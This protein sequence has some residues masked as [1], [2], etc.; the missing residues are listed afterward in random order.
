VAEA[1]RPGSFPMLGSLRFENFIFFISARPFFLMDAPECAIYYCIVATEIAVFG[2]SD[3]LGKLLQRTA[4]VG[5]G[6][7]RNIFVRV[8]N[9]FFVF[10]KE[11]T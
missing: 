4:D 11:Y 6:W 2:G 7:R 8:V 5:V 10:I 9:G 3:G 1:D